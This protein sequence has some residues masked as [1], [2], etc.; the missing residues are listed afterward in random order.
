MAKNDEISEETRILSVYRVK[1]TQVRRYAELDEAAPAKVKGEYPTTVEEIGELLGIL[2]AEVV[3]QAR[4]S[5]PKEPRKVKKKR[6]RNLATAIASTCFGTAA[7]VGDSQFPP[8]FAF[9]YGVGGI[10]LHQALR[11]IIGEPSS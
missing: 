3:R 1:R 6:K 10:A 4:E 7:I 2:H 11:D 9:S 5:R 8:A